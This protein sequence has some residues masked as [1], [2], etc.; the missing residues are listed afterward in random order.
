MLNNGYIELGRYDLDHQVRPFH[1]PVIKVRRS[2]DLIPSLCFCLV[3]QYALA[4]LILIYKLYEGSGD[5]SEKL[6]AK[7]N[8]PFMFQEPCLIETRDFL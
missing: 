6:N 5:L 2:Y 7:E 8:L 3:K 1:I 4:N